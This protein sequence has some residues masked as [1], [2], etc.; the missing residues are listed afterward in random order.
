MD[1]HITPMTAVFAQVIAGWHYEGEYRFYDADQDPEDLEELLDPES[2]PETFFAVLN[3]DQT[4]VGYFIF[5]HSEDAVEIGLGLAPEYTGQGLG[6]AFVNAGLEFARQR[7]QPKIFRLKV[8]TFNQ[9]A[10][11]VYRQA[12]FL[13]GKVYMQE[14]NGRYYEFLSMNRPTS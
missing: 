10:I 13:A 14:V 4:L 9:R 11:R 2:W 5:G 1:Y 8:A 12:G 7:F 3:A 6:L